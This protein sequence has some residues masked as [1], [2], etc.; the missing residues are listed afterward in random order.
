MASSRS[1][2]I[3]I[4][5]KTIATTRTRKTMIATDNVIFFMKDAMKGTLY[6][7]LSPDR[8]TG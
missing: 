5:T 2:K 6:I 3:I 4:I 1:P 8:E 7:S